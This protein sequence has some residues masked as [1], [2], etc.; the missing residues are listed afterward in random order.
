MVKPQTPMSCA[1]RHGN[2]AKSTKLIV[3]ELLC[4]ILIVALIHL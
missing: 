3:G 1:M 2:E 4:K